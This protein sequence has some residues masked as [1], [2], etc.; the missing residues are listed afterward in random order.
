MIKVL[1]GIPP[2]KHA[3]SA[4]ASASRSIGWSACN[5]NANAVGGWTRGDAGDGVAAA[6]VA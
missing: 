1:H 5:V 4:A 2:F 6:A 3:F